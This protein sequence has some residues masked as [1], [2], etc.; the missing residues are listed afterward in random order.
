M[1]EKNGAM[2]F[3]AWGMEGIKGVGVGPSMGRGG[4]RVD[5]GIDTSERLLIL[6]R[7]Y[8]VGGSRN[9]R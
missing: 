8:K 3:V 7:G 9:H 1:K 5:E 6:G 2:D 4:G